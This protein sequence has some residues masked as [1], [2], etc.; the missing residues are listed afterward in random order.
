ML[1]ADNY[2]FRQI[3]H[4][5]FQAHGL[6]PPLV[7]GPNSN[8]RQDCVETI[9]NC[10]G[11]MGS[12]FPNYPDWRWND[13]ASFV[14]ESYATGSLDVV[15]WHYYPYYGQN[16]LTKA[17]P[18]LPRAEHALTDPAFLQRAAV[19]AGK[20]AD[21]QMQHAPTAPSWLTA[22][23]SAGLGGVPNVSDAFASTLW[24]LDLLGTLAVTR[25]SLVMRDEI[26]CGITNQWGNISKANYAPYCI[27]NVHADQTVTVKPDYFSVL[28][29][30]RLVG[31]RVLSATVIP[32]ATFGDDKLRAY[33][34]CGTENRT[35]TTILIN[36]GATPMNV[37]VV[38]SLQSWEPAANAK[39]VRGRHIW[40]L[41]AGA[42]AT[43][44]SNSLHSS[45][46]NINGHRMPNDGTLPTEALLAGVAPPTGAGSTVLLPPL[47]AA[48][49]VDPSLATECGR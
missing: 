9:G 47:S 28:L 40:L 18:G 4:I 22:T 11:W 24:Q 29:F 20:Y 1:A 33:A 16:N 14:K 21:L 32:S 5:A 42:D 12:G 26:F 43:A 39:A 17:T 25:T 34:F 27:I 38:T 37:T 44:N 15:G 13:T 10:P 48:F 46:I 36:L 45:R 7:N 35:V 30:K 49:V 23:A 31:Q 8:Q 41:T 3:V 2:K 19:R 6:R